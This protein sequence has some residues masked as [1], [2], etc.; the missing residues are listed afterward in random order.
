MVYT[1]FDGSLRWHHTMQHLGEDEHGTW[2][3]A[4]AGTGYHRWLEKVS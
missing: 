2:L 4:P 3:G 1:K